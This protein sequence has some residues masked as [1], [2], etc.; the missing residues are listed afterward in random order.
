MAL[1]VIETLSLLVTLRHLSLANEKGGK[2]EDG[3]V[4]TFFGGVE[5]IQSNF[6]L[7]E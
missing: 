6:Q 7:A 3:G 4:S 1:L 5:L 2:N